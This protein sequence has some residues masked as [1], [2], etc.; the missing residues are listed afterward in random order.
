[1]RTLMQLVRTTPAPQPVR[2]GTMTQS[3]AGRSCGF[4]PCASCA[5]RQFSVC[6]P[7][8]EQDRPGFF[9]MGQRLRIE[10]RHALCSEGEPAR[11]VFSI[12]RGTISLSKSLA[13]GRRQ[14]TGFLGDGD[15]VG[16]AQGEA[17]G[18]TAEALTP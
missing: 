16:L 7:V 17:C 2:T 8:P 10:P 15:F 9:G 1:M 6:A 4:E 5:S 14:I 12:S 13:D 11:Y 18:Y 3:S